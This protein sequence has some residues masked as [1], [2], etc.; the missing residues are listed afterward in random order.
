MQLLLQELKLSL[1]SLKDG[2]HCDQVLYIQGRQ[3]MNSFLILSSVYVEL[4]LYIHDRLFGTR[5]L[6]SDSFT[7]WY[8][9]WKLATFR[10][11]LALAFFSSV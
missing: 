3:K 4:L 8:K 6:V 1:L 5:V 11:M 2:L 7:V 9:L 10:R